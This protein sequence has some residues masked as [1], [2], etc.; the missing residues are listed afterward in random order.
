[1][2][3]QPPALVTQIRS[4][5]ISVPCANLPATLEFFVEQLGFRVDLIFP[6]DSPSTAV[7]SGH[8]VTLR[9]EA[10]EAA[11]PAMRLSCDLSSL[12]KGTPHELV[13]PNGM[14][15]KLV[16]ANLPIEVPEVKQEFVISRV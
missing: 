3:K 4:A 10:S 5:Q 8:G 11:L 15:I 9:L 12:P 1:M 2:N 13:A 16:E 6:A 14:R 7:I